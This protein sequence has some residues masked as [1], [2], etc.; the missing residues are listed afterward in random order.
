MSKYSV[1]GSFGFIGQNVCNG[2]DFLPNEDDKYD[3]NR[4]ASKTN[5]IVYLISTTHNYHV[6]DNNPYVDIKTN[7][8]HLMTVL[9]ANKM[10]YG[11]DFEITFVSSWFVYG[12]VDCPA[13]ESFVCNPSG[14][15]SITKLTAERLL[16]SYCDTFGIKYKIVRLANVMG[17][18]DTKISKRKNAMQYMVKTLCDG[19]TVDLYRG[20]FYRDFIHVKDASKGIRKVARLG[21]Y[22]EIY[23]VGSGVGSKISDLV[24]YAYNRIQH[25]GTINLIDVPEFHK[26]VQVDSMWLNPS[27]TLKKTGWEFTI[28][29]QKIIDELIS[30]YRKTNE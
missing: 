21:D 3:K 9:Q 15:Y 19:G 22:G 2:D 12:N 20:N 8:M 17:I 24:Y 6:L 4:F 30:H 27:K 28:P 25:P 13:H 5:K 29:A 1:Y 26:Q 7:L 11:T 23:N 16:A 10:K 14:F 18:G